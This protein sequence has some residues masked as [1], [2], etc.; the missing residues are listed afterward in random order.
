[1]STHAT[2][3]AQKRDG[4]GKGVA[5]K[6]RA[7]GRVPA[8]VYGQGEDAV[9]LTLDAHDARHLFERISVENTIVE[10]SVDGEVME[11]LVRE[12]QVHPFRPELLHVDFYKV[13]KGVK[14]HVEIPV[15]LIGTPEG[16]KSHGGV[17]QQ[18]VH[19]LPVLTIPSLIPDSFEV[20]VSGLDVGDSLHVSDIEL[21]EGVEVQLDLERTLCSVIIPK[22]LTAEEEGEVDDEEGLEPELVGEEGEGGEPGEDEGAEDQDRAGG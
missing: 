8:V 15:H 6:L 17:L 7:G 13:Q 16:V 19:D 3:H 20:D 9:A 21:P 1:M 11:T 22:G 10:L 2:L 12:V 4:T 18:V 5:R 14:V